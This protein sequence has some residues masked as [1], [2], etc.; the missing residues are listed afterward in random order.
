MVAASQ[1]VAVVAGPPQS[2][3]QPE[4]DIVELSCSAADGELSCE[5]GL[6]WGRRPRPKDARR[7]PPRFS[8]PY[9]RPQRAGARVHSATPSAT[10]STV[11]PSRRGAPAEKPQTRARPDGSARSHS[12]AGGLVHGPLN[13]AW[14]E[15]I[16][17]GMHAQGRAEAGHDSTWCATD[18]GAGSAHKSSCTTNGGAH[19]QG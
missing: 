2:Q 6:M 18:A 14:H 13:R 19:S 4:R 12:S 3:R 5:G 15:K 7:P 9:P 17:C 1:G 10:F 11:A 8:R 16:R